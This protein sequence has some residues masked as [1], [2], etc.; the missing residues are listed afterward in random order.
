MMSKYFWRFVLTS[1]VLL[2]I[3]FYIHSGY[4]NVL[5]KSTMIQSYSVNFVLGLIVF[6]VIE[7]LKKKR[8]DILGYIFLA[9]SF[10]KFLI[11]FVYIYPLLIQTGEL[12]K[13]KFFVFFIPYSI[14]L[15][16]EIIFLVRLMNN[17]TK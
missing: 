15:V 7:I 11:Y 6:A 12:T 14:C 5:D 2:S 3:S 4:V 1:L 16:V 9:G 13:L 8:T 17:E 10:L